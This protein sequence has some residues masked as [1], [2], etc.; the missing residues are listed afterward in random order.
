MFDAAGKA[1]AN[2]APLLFSLL[3]K[4]HLLNVSFFSLNMESDLICFSVA[5]RYTKP[6]E[7][8]D[9]KREREACFAPLM[10]T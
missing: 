6:F 10:D 1:C 4:L 7:L 8:F 9:I 2:P 5:F 3:E